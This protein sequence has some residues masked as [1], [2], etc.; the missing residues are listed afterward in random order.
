MFLSQQRHY[1]NTKV[2]SKKVNLYKLKLTN[3]WDYINYFD[4]V[5]I[6]KE[7]GKTW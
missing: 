6:I 1:E 5:I 4:D 2:R 7:D 3:Q